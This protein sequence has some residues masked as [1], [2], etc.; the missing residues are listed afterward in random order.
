MG[1]GCLKGEPAS[2]VGPLFM[3]R[4]CQSALPDASQHHECSFQ[5]A[6]IAASVRATLGQQ[7]KGAI[8][9]P[10]DCSGHHCCEGAS[11]NSS[12][13]QQCC[14]RLGTDGRPRVLSRPALQCGVVNKAVAFGIGSGAYLPTLCFLLL[15]LFF[16][17]FLLSG[18][19]GEQHGRHREGGGRGSDQCPGGTGVFG[20][21]FLCGYFLLFG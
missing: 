20:L 10:L 3:S 6:R 8:I 15:L 7:L 18:R 2:R 21:L 4:V 1:L 19:G 9:P 14:R 17:L 16:F 12:S 11:Q 13:C 5:R